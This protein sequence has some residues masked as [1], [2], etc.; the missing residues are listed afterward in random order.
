MRQVEVSKVRVLRKGTNHLRDHACT[1]RL[2]M[3]HGGK[4]R[5]CEIIRHGER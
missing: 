5:S 3:L 4:M 1:R 2:G